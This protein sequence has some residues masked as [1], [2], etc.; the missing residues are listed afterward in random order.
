[1]DAVYTFFRWGGIYRAH[2][3]TTHVKSRKIIYPPGGGVPNKKW[4]ALFCRTVCCHTPGIY[5]GGG[6]FD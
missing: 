4:G 1:M 6:G 2:P 3:S 5:I